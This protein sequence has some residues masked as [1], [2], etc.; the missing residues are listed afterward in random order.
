MKETIANQPTNQPSRHAG[1]KPVPASL[2]R[3]Y[4]EP[5]FSTN[6]ANV[7]LAAR[8]LPHAAG[9]GCKYFRTQVYLPVLLLRFDTR[10]DV[11]AAEDWTLGWSVEGS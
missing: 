2:K 1:E 5:R 7:S 10:S 4:L 3:D 9:A 6:P 11:S 8:R